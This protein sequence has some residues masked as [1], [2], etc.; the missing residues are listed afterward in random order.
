MN[1]HWRWAA[2]KNGFQEA[3]AYRWEFLIE[4]LTEALVPVMTQIVLWYA[5]FHMSGATQ[6]GG[7]SYQDLITYS[8]KE[9][10]SRRT[11]E[12]TQVITNNKPHWLDDPRLV[13][14]NF[15]L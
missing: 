1:L 3:T 2:L 6:I 7:L 10:K 15:G 5:L 12:L 11:K 4:V 8:K 14:F 13:A 9:G